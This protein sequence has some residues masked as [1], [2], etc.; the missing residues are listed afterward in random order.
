MFSIYAASP[1]FSSIPDIKKSCTEGPAL[2]VRYE[3]FYFSKLL[4]EVFSLDTTDVDDNND[5]GDRIIIVQKK[6]V[7]LRDCKPKVP[8]KYRSNNLAAVSPRAPNVLVN[9]SPE[10]SYRSLLPAFGSPILPVTSGL[11][12][13]AA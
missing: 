8:I 11:S 13:P 5:S 2:T 10:S 6:K 3:L 12:P 4:S 1:L 7:V 9:A